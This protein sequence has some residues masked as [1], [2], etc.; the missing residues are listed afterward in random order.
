MMSN[1][2]A[3]GNQ[4]QIEALFKESTATQALVDMASQN[5]FGC[6]KNEAI[7]F[8]SNIRFRMRQE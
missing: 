3:G 8:V 4:T 6:A 7:H 5:A 2:A 1:I